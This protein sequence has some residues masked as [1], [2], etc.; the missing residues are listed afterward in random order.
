MNLF[1]N[2]RHMTINFS[3]K[4]IRNERQ[5][6][7]YIVLLNNI[8]YFFTNGLYKKKENI[9]SNEK[10]FFDF[11]YILNDRHFK[12]DDIYKGNFFYGISNILREYSGYSNKI[13]SCIEHGVYFGDYVNELEANKSGLPSM[14]TFSNNRKKHI[15][16]YTDKPVFVIGPYINYV[17]D[18][19][20]NKE[21]VSIKESLGKTLLVFP[22]H[23]IDR[24]TSEYDA[25]A[26]IEEIIKVKKNEKINTVLVCMYWK[27][28][29]LNKHSIY[30]DSGFKIVTNGY[31]ED[32]LFLK[33]LKLYIDLSDYTMSNSVGTH[34]GYAITLGKPHYI[35]S[36]KISHNS[37]S[38]IAYL[39]EKNLNEFTSNQEKS[40]V[41]NEFS[42]F[43]KN[44]TEKQLF[45]CDKY[46]GINSV[47][48]KKELKSIL[49]VCSQ[50]DKNAM[51]KH[52]DKSEDLNRQ[53]LAA[54]KD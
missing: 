44:I 19:L 22:V 11:K 26:F 21:F 13:I 43:N 30:E 40:E 52:Y 51:K 16:K 50:I 47:K 33:R 53:L 28:I 4:I 18:I 48:S 37:E 5:R 25:K 20:K 17:D 42:I 35:F 6:K 45:V 39:E 24:I 2:I 8:K 3:K 9:I 46:W 32:P 10:L 38:K 49:E 41:L 29:L 12:A 15:R 23:S 54:L 7:R 14:I 36:Q 34:V 27:D 1:H 31:R